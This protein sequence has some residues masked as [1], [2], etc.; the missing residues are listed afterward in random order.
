[1]KEVVTKKEI[2]ELIELGYKYAAFTQEELEIYKDNYAEEIAL[3]IFEG[4]I[5]FPYEKMKERIN[6]ARSK[7]GRELIG[8]YYLEKDNEIS[9]ISV[10]DNMLLKGNAIVAVTTDKDENGKYIR[11]AYDGNEE[12]FNK[13]LEQGYVKTD[14][15]DGLGL[16]VGTTKLNDLEGFSVEEAET[17][18]MDAIALGIIKPGHGMI[19]P[20]TH[21]FEMRYKDYT[22]DLDFIPFQMPQKMIMKKR[23][24]KF[25][26]FNLK[27][28]KNEVENEK[29]KELCK[30]TPYEDTKEYA[31]KKAHS[32]D[33]GLIGNYDHIKSGYAI[34]GIISGYCG[35][36]Y[37]SMT[38]NTQNQWMQ[39]AVVLRGYCLDY[40]ADNK[41]FP[42]REQIIEYYKTKGLDLHDPKQVEKWKEENKVLCFDKDYYYQDMEID[43][44][45]EL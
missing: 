18:I 22:Y 33:R 20:Y 36:D 8:K 6:I 12:K 28:L 30:Y 32:W 44:E 25:S 37:S 2:I 24:G 21:G 10:N 14:K 40:V 41:Y 16:A 26:S 7:Y 1:M 35:G 9:C 11:F 19:A 17:I 38:T 39:A 29:N 34:D 3:R 43:E 5:F 4:D 13:L 42:W 45:M 15:Y 27:E 31:Y 23:L